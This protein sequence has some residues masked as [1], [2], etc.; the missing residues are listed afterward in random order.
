MKTPTY[1][2]ILSILCFFIATGISKA[3][4]TDKTP[5]PNYDLA[6]KF[7]PTQLAKLGTLYQCKPSL[8][9]KWE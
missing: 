9:Q 8:A 1:T 6:A 2:K 7:S 5:A 4:Q 3:Q